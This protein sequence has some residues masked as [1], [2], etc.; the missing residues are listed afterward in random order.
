MTDTI[1][2]CGHVPTP[3][4]H[5]IGTGYGRDAADGRTYCYACC[6]DRE[7]ARMVESG[8]ATLYLSTA[9]REI[10]DW[11]GMLRFRALS[12]RK[13]RHNIARTRY[14]VGFVGP[15]GQPWHGVQYGDNTEIIHCKRVKART[16]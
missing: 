12:I 13:G 10:T 9:T 4:A 1:L 6:A 3:D 15:D 5:G 2:D 16:R 8:R 14:D 11:P 7:R